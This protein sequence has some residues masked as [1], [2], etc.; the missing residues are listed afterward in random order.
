MHDMHLI[1]DGSW[2]GFKH[3]TFHLVCPVVPVALAVGV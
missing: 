2:Q 3:S 1:K